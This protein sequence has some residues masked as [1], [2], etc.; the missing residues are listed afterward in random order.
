MARRV[1][2]MQ[3]YFFPYGGY[4]RLLSETDLFVIYDCVQFPREGRV[5]RAQVP[6]PHGT[7]EWLTLPLQP[8]PL[9]T[10][11]AGQ[12]FHPN[13]AQLWAARTKRFPW[14]GANK[15]PQ[16]D[17]LRALLNNFDQPLVDYLESG[18][19]HACAALGITTPILRSTTL[20]IPPDLRGQSR[21]IATA[22]AVGATHYLNAPGGR[23]LYDAPSFA[24]HGL[25]LE[26]LP[27]YT[28]PLQ[29]L[30]PAMLAGENL[31]PQSQPS[32]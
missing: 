21:V 7:E 14:Y 25:K 22:Q 18:L 11:I 20:D 17:A 15:T 9:Q 16:A 13:A 4:F 32:I 26:F 19:R 2:I 23:A 12:R 3:P 5:H 10:P 28:G 30:L 6:G 1:A 29:H 8:A 27:P 24:T 31:R